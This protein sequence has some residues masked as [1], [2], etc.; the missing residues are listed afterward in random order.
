MCESVEVGP[1]KPSCEDFFGVQG[2]VRPA[3]EVALGESGQVGVV[4]MADE[5]IHAACA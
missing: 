2:A 3:D 1:T 5:C 4:G